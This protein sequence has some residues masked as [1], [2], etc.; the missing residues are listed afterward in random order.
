M[1]SLFAITLVSLYGLCIRLLFI[2][3]GGLTQIMSVTF[4]FL[5]PMA[6]GYL[7]V[8]LLPAKNVQ[9][10]LAAF[11]MPWLT[12]LV[13]L[14]ITLAFNIEGAICWVMAFPIFAILAGQGGLIAYYRRKKA[15][16]YEPSKDDNDNNIIDTP[17]IFQVSI[18]AILPLLLGV[19]EGNRTQ[20]R[21]DY[22]IF[23]EIT[24]SAPP[25]KVWEALLNINAIEHH[26]TK[27]SFST[28]M[29]FPNHIETT[30][31]TLAIGGK[32]TA[33]YEKGLFFEEIIT[34]YEPE[35]R[36]VLDINTDPTKIPPTVMDEHIVIGG[37]HLDILEDVYNLRALPDGST[38]VTLSSRFF[39]N[40][41]F[42]WYSGIWAKYL[43]KDILQNELEIIQK[44][45]LTD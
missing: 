42:N 24:I 14:A 21:L 10:Y 23:R 1:K 15:A 44:R 35:K 31:D 16:G 36:L 25:S 22:L 13:I 8:F 37:K 27:R 40:T 29:G 3:I 2:S 5:V 30:L 43:M 38:Q 9:S 39:I 4:I 45:A 11:F 41:P 26:E 17:D 32:R 28:L 7:T 34:D 6:I 20:T 19:A 12:S 33:T 18:I